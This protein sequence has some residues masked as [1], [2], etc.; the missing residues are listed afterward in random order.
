MRVV[1]L[2]HYFPPEVGAPQ[3]RLGALA[4]GLAARGVDVRV[5]APF[6]HYPDGLI[7]APY[8]NRPALIERRSPVLRSAV[9]ATPNRGFA[10][11]LAN[12]LSFA[13]SALATHPL[14]G[15]A[16]VVMVESPPL[17][18]AAA[19]VLYARAKRAPLVVNVA[20][21]WPAS[22]VQLGALGDRRAIAAAEALERWCY[23][24]AA[25]VTVP[26]R[27]LESALAA[28]PE[29][30][31]KVQRIGP[32]VDLERFAGLPRAG[33]RPGPLRLL[34]AGTIGIAQGLDTLVEAAARAGPQVVAVR[35]A[36]GGAEEA[37]VRATV[38]RLAAHNV[39]LLGVVPADRVPGLYDWA[40]AGS[41]LL[42]DRP[43]TSPPP[44]PPSSST[45]WPRPGRCSSRGVARPPSWFAARAPVSSRHRG[46]P[47]PWPGRSR[48]SP[49]TA[50]PSQPWAPPDGPRPWRA[51]PGQ[52]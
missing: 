48:A 11:R 34:Y 2:T 42:R 47:A 12:H 9:Y 3:A 37:Q 26:T 19:G 29:A 14:T 44:C 5:H 33:S 20:D 28:L 41:V 24:H 43:I 21:R 27:G 31:G 10:R 1:L 38:E 7:Q 51:S 13:A 8:R 46:I 49:T 35:I 16:D 17:F 45:R 36:G 25:T 22:A 52:R 6:P 23:R 30:A 15:P 4:R 40:D 32:A 39:E 18:L 50:G